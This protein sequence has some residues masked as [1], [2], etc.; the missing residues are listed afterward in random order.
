M[1]FLS[2]ISVLFA[3]FVIAGVNL[4]G[5]LPARPYAARWED[6]AL[7]LC[8]LSCG[9]S[10]FKRVWIS[11]LAN[12]WWL[13]AVPVA[14]YLRLAHQTPLN[15]NFTGFIAETSSAEMW[16]FLRSTSVWFV[17]LGAVYFVA[18]VWI[19]Y[20]SAKQNVMWVGRTRLWVLAGG[21]LG[22]AAVLVAA[23]AWEQPQSDGEERDRFA[24]KQ[25]P[26]WH[27]RLEKVFPFDLALSGYRHVEDAR[28]L[29]R[30][31][32]SNAAFVFGAKPLPATAPELVVL[33]I[34]ES[35]RADRW[36]L[37][38]YNKPTTPLLDKMPNVFPFNDV[39]S[40]S[41]ATRSSVP[42]ML[43][44]RPAVTADGLVA[45]VVEPSVTRL[46][47][48]SGYQTWWASNQSPSGF[49]E[50]TIGF[51]AKEADNVRYVNPGAW[52]AFASLDEKLL[53]TLA[54]ALTS[55]KPTF[56]VLHT[57]GS[58][59]NYAYRYPESFDRFKPSLSRSLDFK[60]ETVGLAVEASNSYDNSVAYTDAFLADVIGKLKATGRS[61]ALMYM[62]DHAD[63]LEV[64]GCGSRGAG[65]RTSSTAYKVPA[66]LWLSDA[67]V[68]A[69]PEIAKAATAAKG[70]RLR[71]DVVFDTLA[72]LAGIT[73]PPSPGRAAM[74]AFTPV[75]QS[76]QR[77]VALQTSGF[78]DI[79]QVSS[80]QRCDITQL[81]QLIKP[82]LGAA[83]ARKNTTS[84]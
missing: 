34:G 45:T 81:H 48:Q 25:R 39:V 9:F 55:P 75:P 71:G 44:R 32:D 41:A 63:D 12:S 72:D 54:S 6:V 51:Y 66:F 84:N 17:A 59:F 58:H 18:L 50:N 30:F 24:M 27:D 42:S 8:L 49:Y 21:L 56:M 11:W 74:S 23:Q 20:K 67:Y 52:G 5:T 43:A 69:R 33:V 36:S 46:F 68:A 15:Q 73:V 13:L 79:D 10:I 53:P 3:V 31:R 29:A 82:N 61:A 77:F 60:R 38:G 7:A 2:V 4:L 35:S 37:F 22:F 70:S 83:V 14:L 78:I 47:S 40:V 1:G 80:E 76:S 19:V 62:S 16:N 28:E 26:V 57:M 65:M 64:D